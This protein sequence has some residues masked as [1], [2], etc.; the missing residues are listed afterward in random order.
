ME[1]GM[2]LAVG[3]YR[4]RS[5]EFPSY[6]DMERFVN[7]DGPDGEILGLDA[8]AFVSF[9]ALEVAEPFGLRSR[10][11]GLVMAGNNGGPD[12]LALQGSASLLV[13]LNSEVVLIDLTKAAIR[14]FDLD[15]WFSAFIHEGNVVAAI[16]EL[17][18]LALRL[19]EC[20][21]VGTL[22]TGI[23]SE[24]SLSNRKL[25]LISDDGSRSELDLSDLVKLF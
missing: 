9:W 13:G 17:G 18:A 16:H 12:V 6:D 23:V 21:V 7:A 11:F 19:P 22:S 1:L 2:K 24:A 15:A 5:L 10:R 8:A 20:E 25:I 14:K 4:V 3:S